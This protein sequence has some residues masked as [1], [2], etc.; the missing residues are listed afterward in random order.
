LIII[1]NRLSSFLYLEF[2]FSVQSGVGMVK[3]EALVLP[4]SEGEGIPRMSKSRQFST[5]LVI[6]LTL[7]LVLHVAPASAYV[8]PGAGFALVSSF[9]T[10]LITFAMAFLTLLT[11][12]V[13]WI[14][15]SARRRRA[16]VGSRV[17]RVVVLGLD[18][19]DP[20]LAERMMDRG[21]LPNFAQL[22]ETGT[23][24]RLQTTF[25]AVSPVAWSSFQT[26]C[27]PG[28]HRIFDFLEPNRHNYLPELSS[29]KIGGPSRT[30]R[31]GKYRIPIGKASIQLRRK[32]RP[33]W[34]ILG[35][36][37]VF[38]SI[39]RVPITFP[40]EKFHGVLLSAMCVPDLKG[41]QGTFSY[42][43]SDPEEQDGRFTGGVR[44]PL[45]VRDGVSESYLAGPENSLVPNAGEMRLPFT[46]R[47][48]NNAENAT[49]TIANK[50]IDLKGGEYTEWVPVEFRPGLFVR[51]RGICRFLLKSTSPHLRLYVT[52][53]QI[54]PDR[55]ALPISHP[56]TY[57]IYL[58]KTLGRY[59]TLGLAEDTW[60][61]NERV[62]DEDD[63]LRQVWD[64][65]AER[66]AM[67]FDALEKTRRGV[68]A[69]VFDT[70]DR[71]QHMF[72]RYLEPDHPANDGKEA[73]KHRDAIPELY[74]K[75]DGLLGRTLE[76]LEDDSV[77]F[78]MS[79]H[80]F[81]LFRRGVNLNSWLYA[82][83]Y[84][85]VKGER[86]EGKEWFADVDWSRTRAYA[87]GLG[88]MYLNIK[89]RESQGVVSPG[90]E[91]KNLKLE[92]IEKL[93][94]L[95]DPDEHIEAVRE[96]YD[97]AAIYN[98]PY[99][100][101]APDLLI[102]FASG[103]RASWGCATGVVDESV[104]EDN[105]KSWSG[106]HC[107]NPVDVPGVLFS[108]RKIDSESPRITD[109]AP[110]VLDLFGVA[111]PQYFDGRSLMPKV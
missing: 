37:G 92:I 103:Y 72:W 69:C 44:I 28:K 7:T 61:L 55:P 24:R 13:R 82:N 94:G 23:F 57:A 63:F 62:I 110:T 56:F 30:L 74:R 36:H 66:E 46:L 26:G 86:P 93:R 73:E 48:G 54:D 38:S 31:L 78:V 85:A 19:M 52:P 100:G 45:T 10:L 68:V 16:L 21:E 25:P 89:G 106:D 77:L 41:T 34:K 6:V 5:G 75:M 97:S 101:E 29:A 27:N 99:V 9:M 105:T 40:P 12:P 17:R 8:G 81:K 11:W 15:L 84:L 39:L 58:A 20:D 83:D 102:G 49:L 71:M 96:V 90:D 104:F 22:R 53:I 67:F 35:D 3:Y 43:S 42:Y 98:G 64:H 95:M 109:I 2:V 107:V 65:H 88:G 47:L 76:R 4:D 80:G 108:N 87:V 91:A 79:D 33:F 51:V 14:V 50:K 59:A 32:S 70:T 111:V 1:H 60:A 18:G